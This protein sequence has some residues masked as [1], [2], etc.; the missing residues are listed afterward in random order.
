MNLLGSSNIVN[1]GQ[2]GF[3]IEEIYLLDEAWFLINCTSLLVRW[4][5]L[6]KYGL[7]RSPAN[8]VSQKCFLFWC[9]QDGYVLHD[10][11][12]HWCSYSPL[13][14]EVLEGYPFVKEM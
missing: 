2:G 3:H 14:C 8:V 13:S 5:V 1:G 11:A 12:F 6:V 10:D 9:G 4:L 7:Y